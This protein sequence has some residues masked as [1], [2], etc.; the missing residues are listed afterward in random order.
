M[1]DRIRSA[2]GFALAASLSFLPRHARA[3]DT[4]A[5][6]SMDR[7]GSGTAWLPDAAAQ[8]ARHVMVGEWTVMAHGAAF[9]QFDAQGGARGGSQVNLLNWAMVGASRIVAGGRFQAR[10]MLSLD[11]LTVRDGGY[12]LLL[13]SG[14][15]WH[16][17]PL[18]D[19]QHPHDFLGELALLYERPVAG[20]VG[21][22]WYAAASGEPALGP[23][24]FI[25]RASAAD[26]PLAPLGHHWQDATHISF[27]VLTA[28]VYTG[29]WKFEASSFNG[30]EPDENRWNLDPVRLDSY[31][32]RATWN[33]D[34]N[35]S[36]TAGYGYFANPEPAH[37]GES[38]HRATA[39]VLH[40]R[41]IGADG[42]WA[43]S[44]VWGANVVGS[45][46]AW[47]SSV[48]L[49]TELNLDARNAIFGRAESVQKTADDLA[50]AAAPHA[51]DSGRV[52]AVSALTLG[53]ARDLGARGGVS[54]ALGGAA[55]LNLVPSALE[56]AYGSRAPA[57][58][59]VFLRIRPARAA[60]SAMDH[61]HM[62]MEMSR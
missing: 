53:Y 1:T 20:P 7:M 3:Q 32:G 25:H 44:V 51:F 50:L 21:L 10:T 12:P 34:A 27:G 31:S 16:R 43:T 42:R 17:A 35:W 30:R 28:G 45:D 41:P 11:A 48:L 57:G 29:A 14:E 47:T 61:M 22:S 33:P 37:P 55:T 9:A 26:N 40:A 13:Q 15:S 2:A 56:S 38:L 6:P 52:F 58:A 5:V 60:A 8:S 24:A 59:T 39:S 54:M 18:H 46:G 4:A 23:V 49:E 62:P 19:R 36:L